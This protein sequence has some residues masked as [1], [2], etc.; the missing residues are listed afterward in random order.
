MSSDFTLS[1][2]MPHCQLARYLRKN[3]HHLEASHCARHKAKS[4]PEI[5]GFSYGQLESRQLASIKQHRAEVE[6]A[7]DTAK[8]CAHPPC[9]CTLKSGKYCSVQCEAMEDT[10][11]VDCRCGHA[12]CKG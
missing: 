8:K 2:S 1:Q 10:P 7:A 12:D 9:T 4:R 11:D 6:M 3:I 5:K